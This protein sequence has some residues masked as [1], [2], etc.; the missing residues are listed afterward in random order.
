MGMAFRLRFRFGTF[1]A[2]DI[3]VSCTGGTT[4]GR[5]SNPPWQMDDGVRAA[6]PLM[7]ETASTAL[8]DRGAGPRRWDH[9][10]AFAPMRPRSPAIH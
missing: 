4:P 6:M 2:C 10:T 9:I 7:R 3:G 8:G 5:Y 1:C